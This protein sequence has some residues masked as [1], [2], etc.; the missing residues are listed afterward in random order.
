M[1]L[2]ATNR[3]GWF[4]LFRFSALLALLAAQTPVAAHAQPLRL[5]IDCRLGETCFIQNWI[6]LDPGPGRADRACGPLTYNGHDGLD[7]RVPMRAMREGVAVKAPADGV[8]RAV[9]DGESDG[10]YRT[11]GRTLAPDR[12]CGNGVVIDHGAGL[13][14]QLCHMRRGSITARPGLRVS[15]GAVMGLVG[16]SGATEFPHVHISVRR[17]GQKIDPFTGA[18]VAQSSCAASPPRPHRGLWDHPPPYLATAIV[19]MGFTD[20]PPAQAARADDAPAAAGSRLAPAMVAWV[21]IMGVRRGDDTTLRL[22]TPDGAILAENRTPHTR[23]QAQYALF[24]GKR[25]PGAVWPAG[26]YRAEVAVRRGGGVVASR[27]GTLTV[28][29]PLQG[30]ARR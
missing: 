13:E 9:R 25:R 18:P 16:L 1:R 22:L 14:T 2:V 29:Q 30:D 19:D 5:P 11:T 27:T 23:D 24:A 28:R 6:D 8:I 4:S 26:T 17:D 20:A 15:Q 3:A 7:I 10:V 21:I 12:D